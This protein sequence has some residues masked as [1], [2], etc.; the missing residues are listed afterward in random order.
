MR[1]GI[2]EEDE[3]IERRGRVDLDGRLLVP[4][5]T[6]GTRVDPGRH[7]RSRSA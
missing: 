2:D 7:E 6:R 1:D 3:R 5:G 4:T